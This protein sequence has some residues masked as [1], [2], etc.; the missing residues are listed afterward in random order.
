MRPAVPLF[1]LLA[2]ACGSDRFRY[3]HDD[4]L[5]IWHAQVKATHNSYHIQPDVNIQP[6]AY[7]HLPL[8][9]Q[10]SQQAVRAFELDLN[11]DTTT[12]A[13]EV[14]HITSLD[15]RTTCR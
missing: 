11:Y 14:Y 15:D 1:A 10:A 5:T 2:L 8:D 13:L 7:T 12:G 6:W 3:P 9:Q 4:V